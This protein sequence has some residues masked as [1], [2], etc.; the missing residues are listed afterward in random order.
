[1]SRGH[2]PASE[3]GLDPG[4]ARTARRQAGNCA[5]SHFALQ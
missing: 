2:R 3:Y 1:M 5:H 4:P